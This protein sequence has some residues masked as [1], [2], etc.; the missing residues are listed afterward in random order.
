MYMI[1]LNKDTYKLSS[2]GRYFS[3]SGIVPTI[4]KSFAVL[5]STGK[6]QSCK[7]DDRSHRCNKCKWSIGETKIYSMNKWEKLERSSLYTIPFFFLT[8]SNRANPRSAN[9]NICFVSIFERI[10]IIHIYSLIWLLYVYFN[11]NSCN[12]LIFPPRWKLWIV[13]L[14]PRMSQRLGVS[15]AWQGIIEDLFRISPRFL[16]SWQG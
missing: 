5:Y 14:D 2:F 4:F 1:H 12:L 6:Q 15:W 11:D 13:G 7:E 10:W 9:G 16:R 8:G 3:S